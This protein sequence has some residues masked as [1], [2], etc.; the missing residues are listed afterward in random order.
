MMENKQFY[1]VKA[2]VYAA[3][4]LVLAVLLP[5]MSLGALI[6]PTDVATEMGAVWSLGNIIDDSGMGAPQVDGYDTHVNTD[7]STYLWLSSGGSQLTGPINF[8]LG[9]VYDVTNLVIWPPNT[10]LRTTC[11]ISN[12]VVRYIGDDM[13]VLHTSGTLT[14]T[15]AQL[16]GG[17]IKAQVFDIPDVSNVRYMSINVTANCGNG[18]YTGSSEIKFGGTSVGAGSEPAVYDL[19]SPTNATTDMGTVWGHVTKTWD[20]TGVE[21]SPSPLTTTNK[22]GQYASG[23]NMWLSNGDTEGNV[24]YWLDGE[25]SLGGF[26]FWNFN[27]THDTDGSR[28]CVKQFDLSFYDASDVLISSTNNLLATRSAVYTAN[29]T[30]KFWED[31]TGKIQGP[32]N[33]KPCYYA[34]LFTFTKVDGVKKVVLHID[35]A[36]NVPTPAGSYVGLAEVGFLEAASTPSTGGV[37]LFW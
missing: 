20:L 33:A 10:T 1:R 26:A 5:A 4:G 22:H 37:V 12:F 24:T 7:G 19:L 16:D 21:G 9:G 28:R 17:R 3:A 14:G 34:E 18:S 30:Y 23:A 6:T 35:S 13:T 32:L 31:G 11:A 2:S 29:N 15:V 25:Y 27:S 8:D 36:W